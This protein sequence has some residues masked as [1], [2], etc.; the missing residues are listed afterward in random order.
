[1][2][3]QLPAE[4]NIEIYGHRE[5]VG[6]PLVCRPFSRATVPVPCTEGGIPA[7]MP[8]VAIRRLAP[9]SL[10]VALTSLRCN[11]VR[12]GIPPV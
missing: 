11:P 2:C 4:H 9:T 8:F 5:G 12:G 10:S 7:R 1:M 3:S 6:W